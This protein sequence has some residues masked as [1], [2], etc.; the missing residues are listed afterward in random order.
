MLPDFKK[1]CI[2]QELSEPTPPISLLSLMSKGR[3]SFALDK[4]NRAKPP[5]PYKNPASSRVSE[6]G[7]SDKLT[8]AIRASVR[9]S[10]QV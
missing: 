9:S 10:G 4:L 3:I 5:L 8:R 6:R 1:P 7:K 2:L